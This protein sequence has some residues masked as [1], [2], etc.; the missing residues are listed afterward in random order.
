MP[1]KANIIK[2]AYVRR[3]TDNGQVSAY[4][5]WS[6]GSRGVSRGMAPIS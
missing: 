5:E 1:R 3:Y 4:V 6:D 2:A